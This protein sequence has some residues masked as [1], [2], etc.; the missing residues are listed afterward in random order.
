MSIRVLF[1]GSAVA[2]SGDPE[3]AASLVRSAVAR[4]VPV[5]VLCAFDDAAEMRRFL[6]GGLAPALAVRA[7]GLEAC[8]V[9]QI[10]FGAGDL[11]TEVVQESLPALF[12]ETAEEAGRGPDWMPVEVAVALLP[13]LPAG[14][15]P[16]VLVAEGIEALLR[17]PE[18]VRR[19]VF[20]ALALLAKRRGVSVILAL[21]GEPVERVATL[22]GLQWLGEILPAERAA[23]EPAVVPERGRER[24][25]FR[26][27]KRGGRH[28]RGAHA[29]ALGMVS[30][31][32]PA[33][34]GAALFWFWTG[35]GEDSGRDAG[36]RSAGGGTEERTLAGVAGW[37][38]RGRA[39]GFYLE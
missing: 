39:P 28:L 6:R 16:R 21:A 23:A 22:P 35:A 2:V 9:R 38:D 10:G 8:H 12:P 5:P 7:R 26:G 17:Q 18:R 27:R 32:M 15:R 37:T 19:G 34:L 36:A 33:L 20:R 1:P 29:V 13:E 3:V 11:P 24:G 14:S 25:V 31:M 30:G 4:D